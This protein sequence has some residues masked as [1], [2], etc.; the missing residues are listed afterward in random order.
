MW[1]TT[2]RVLGCHFSGSRD[3]DDLDARVQL[4]YLSHEPRARHIGVAHE[5]ADAL[6]HQF[7]GALGIAGAAGWLGFALLSAI[8][9]GKPAPMT[10]RLLETP[11]FGG[12]PP[13]LPL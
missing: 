7:E 8:V 1:P 3:E 12:I 9:R 4:Q 13:I 2:S 10:W 6:E 5:A 11:G